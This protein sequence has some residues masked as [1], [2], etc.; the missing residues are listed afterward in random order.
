MKWYVK[1]LE[2]YPDRAKGSA[3]KILLGMRLK[4]TFINGEGT[5]KTVIRNMA[6]PD[7]PMRLPDIVTVKNSLWTAM[8]TLKK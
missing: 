7:G 5:E 3:N 2:G 4:V 1:S 8:E 6:S